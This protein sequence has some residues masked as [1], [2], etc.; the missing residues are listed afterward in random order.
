MAASILAGATSYADGNPYAGGKLGQNIVSDVQRNQTQ[1]VTYAN[2]QE[3]THL[4]YHDHA[5]V[6]TRLNVMAGL[7][8]HY[9]LRDAVDDGE[10]Q[11]LHP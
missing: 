3:A 6:I 5:I 11:P 4:W 7:A 2:D 9:L 10:G 8:G 1:T